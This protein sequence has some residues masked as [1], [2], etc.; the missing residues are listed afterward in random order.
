MYD[1]ALQLQV[2]QFAEVIAF[3]VYGLLYGA[4]GAFKNHKDG[5]PIKPVHLFKPALVGLVS[6]VIV[7]ARGGEATPA[8]FAGAA[9]MAVPLVDMVLNNALPEK[10][11]GYT[12]TG[13]RQSKGNANSSTTNDPGAPPRL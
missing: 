9:T 2:E 10:F 12:G 7:A 11:G 6:G 8:A 13:W 1:I 4:A 5:E 3:G